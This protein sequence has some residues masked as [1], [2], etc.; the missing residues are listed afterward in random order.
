MYFNVCVMYFN[1]FNMYFN[2]SFVPGPALCLPIRKQ[3]L[4]Q[5]MS[6]VKRLENVL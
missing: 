5:I 4:V 2:S 3:A 1:S 6:E